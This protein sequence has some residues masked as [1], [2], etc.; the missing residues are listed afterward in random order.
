MKIIPKLFPVLMLSLLLTSCFGDGDGIRGSGNVTKDTRSLQGFSKI[1]VDSGMEVTISQGD[2]EVV[3]EADDNIQPH[4]VTSVENGTLYISSDYNS[5]YNATRHITV[6]M[7]VV[8]KLEI[9]SGSSVRSTNTLTGNKI[10]LD[11]D[12]GSS[13]TLDLEADEIDVDANQG[14]SVTLRGIALVFQPS[15]GQGSSISATALTANDIKAEASSGS[16][17]EVHA[18]VSLNAEASSGSSIRYRGNPTQVVI[19]KGS[20]GDV[21][22]N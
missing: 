22:K 7:P 9:G 12:G 6:K 19:D 2:F 16:S 5:F 8:E 1:N 21:S 13:V 20:G 11:V 17:I 3:V 14:S 10:S 18:A 4:V 15:A